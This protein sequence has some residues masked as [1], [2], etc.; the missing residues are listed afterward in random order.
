MTV[1]LR[2]LERYNQFRLHS[3]ILELKN[4]CTVL[5]MIIYNKF[6]FNNHNDFVA[7]EISNSIG[8]LYRN[9]GFVPQ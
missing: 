1:T 8:V 4:H 2:S 5:G 6:K 3:N 7:S 9:K